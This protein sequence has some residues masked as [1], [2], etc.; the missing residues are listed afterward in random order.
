MSLAEEALPIAVRTHCK[1]NG[2]HD[3]ETW[4]GKA[5]H[6]GFNRSDVVTS[7]ETVN[8]HLPQNKY[9]TVYGLT[10]LSNAPETILPTGFG[11]FPFL[12]NVDTPDHCF[13]VSTNQG[14]D[15]HRYFDAEHSV[16]VNPFITNLTSATDWER[17]LRMH[18]QPVSLHSLRTL[19]SSEG[20]SPM[21][22]CTIES[23]L[24]T[25]NVGINSEKKSKIP[26]V[27]TILV[28]G[29]ETLGDQPPSSPKQKLEDITSVNWSFHCAWPLIYTL[30]MEPS[31]SI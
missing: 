30:T 22:W 2:N 14:L 1:E 24:P 15:Q 25:T 12:M 28:A 11:A 13:M 29:D 26:A 20:T 10:L 19:G 3:T 18:R 27:C 17:W 4:S 16:G 6:E 8:C 7:R 5:P 31:V 23:C 9:F 21:S